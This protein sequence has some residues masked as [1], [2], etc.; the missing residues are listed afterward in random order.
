MAISFE[1]LRLENLEKRTRAAGE[2]RPPRK[3]SY[4]GLVPLRAGWPQNEK[5]TEEGNRKDVCYDL[6][7]LWM[8]RSLSRGDSQEKEQ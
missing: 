4:A 1:I 7:I 3:E 5:K 6:K 2:Y 8:R